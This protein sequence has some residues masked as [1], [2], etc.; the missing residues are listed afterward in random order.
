MPQSLQ[1]RDEA[2]GEIL[3]ELD[4]HRWIGDSARGRSS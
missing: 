4:V 1:F 2:L 3:V